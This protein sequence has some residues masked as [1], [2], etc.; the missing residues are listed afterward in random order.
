MINLPV[1][2]EN[3]MKKMLGGE[4]SDFIKA[5]EDEKRVGI[6]VNTLKTD[7]GS[8][9]Q[10][11]PFELKKVKWC[12][13]GFEASGDEKYGREAL[14]D[15]GAFYMQEPSAM[16]VVS[17]L[18]SVKEIKGLKVLDLCAAPGGKSTQLAALMQGEGIL[19][20]NEINR[21]RAQILSSNIERMGVSNCVVL[22]ETPDRIADNFEEYFDVIVV[23]APCSGEGMFRKDE[24]AI[25]EWSPENVTMCAERQKEI[26]SQAVKALRPGGSLVYSTCT[27]APDE[28]EIQMADFLSEYEDFEITDVPV[29]EYFEHGHSGWLNKD[30]PE[31]IRESIRK[32]ARLWTHKID[33]EGHFICV[34]KNISD[35]SPTDAESENEVKKSKKKDKAS[36]RQNGSGIDK[37]TSE[38]INDFIRQ[39]LTDFEY[40]K[41]DLTAVS[42]YIYL[43]PKGFDVNCDKLKVVRKGLELGIIKKD[44]FEPSHSFAMALSKDNVKRSVELDDEEAL[45]YRHGEEIRKDCEN[46]WTLITVKGVSLGWGKAVNGVIKNHYPK[47]LRIKF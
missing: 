23:D 44:R 26:L 33:G 11:F 18:E 16:A 35:E 5:L 27:F 24:T 10:A 21:E 17:A 22:N 37:K 28:D 30:Y 2:F 34:L 7:V 42:D 14:H 6:R 43:Q 13:T 8:F 32:C 3:R 45:K 12:K 1:E 4:Y 39:N 40:T 25:T 41:E 15:A 29:F 46:G 20:S 31:R 19:V 38:L 9:T 36:K 47:G